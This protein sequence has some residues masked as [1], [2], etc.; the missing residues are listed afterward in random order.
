[1]KPWNLSI[2]KQFLPFPDQQGMNILRQD[3]GRGMLS[4]A[5]VSVARVRWDHRARGDPLPSLWTFY[6][7]WDGSV[8]IFDDMKKKT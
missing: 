3:I 1:M 5:F 8:L 6:L 7:V 2:T 4:D